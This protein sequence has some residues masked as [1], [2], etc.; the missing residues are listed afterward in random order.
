MDIDRKLLQHVF[1][2]SVQAFNAAAVQDLDKDLSS[3][4]RKEWNAIYASFE[5]RSQLR[6]RVIGLENVSIPVGSLNAEQTELPCFVVMQYLVKVLIPAP[7]FWMDE[8]TRIGASS[9]IGAEVE[10]VIIGVE[11]EGECAAASRIIALEQQRWFSREVRDVQPGDVVPAQI[12]A[13]GPTRLTVTACGYDVVLG[14]AAISYSYLEDL[15]NIYHIGQTLSAK[16]LAIDESML[17]LSM[18]ETGPD[19]YESAEKRHPVG[20]C[21]VG[22]I[23]NKY[24]G[25]VF[26][27]LPDGCTVVCKYAQQFSDDQFHIGDRVLIQIRSFSDDRHWLRGKIRSKIG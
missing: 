3:E 24:R 5:S 15:R 14:Q 11:R 18:R 8:H 25:G 9:A 10:Y 27:R 17:V 19:P 6:G 4:Q 26:C 23:T 13:V 7:L 2:T 16:V 21:R 1:S 22:T 12:L 20:S